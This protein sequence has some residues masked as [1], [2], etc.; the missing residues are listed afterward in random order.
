MY[1]GYSMPPRRNAR[2]AL[3]SPPHSGPSKPPEKKSQKKQE[4]NNDDRQDEPNKKSESDDGGDVVD[5]SVVHE[6][7]LTSVKAALADFDSKL[8]EGSPSM[9]QLIPILVTAVSLAVTESVKDGVK[10]AM[11]VMTNAML[12]AENRPRPTSNNEN[13]LMAA[14]TTL[15]YDNDRLQQYTRRESIRIHGIAIQEGET[16]LDV[17][18]K[19][20][21]V[22]TDV[23]VE[24]KPEDMSAVHRAGKETKGT[25]PVLVK[26][27][28]RR[29]RRQ[30]MEKKKVLKNKPGYAHV[31]LT[32]DLTPLRARLLGL[33][34]R[35][36]CIDRA[37]TIDGRIQCVKKH[38]HGM[39][40][41]PRPITIETPDDLFDKL[42]VQN[43]DME[44][45][46]LSH[47]RLV[48]VAV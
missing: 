28:S 4:E 21:K 38:P 26:F 31:F 11:K 44:A 13:R 10:E 20:I 34:K 45:L 17:E 5:T 3:F 14:V 18:Q 47:L 33:V 8:D 41:S 29:V 32:D 2:R 43:V 40:P 48:D 19:A 30:V 16:A 7:I 25:R 1:S 9:K 27:V 37:W 23:G 6:A 15:T 39:S 24:V 35:L 22:F 12:N 46:G 42:G 36:E